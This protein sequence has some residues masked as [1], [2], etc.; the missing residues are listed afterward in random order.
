M[1]E[2]V[3]LLLLLVLLFLSTAAQVCREQTHRKPQDKAV[4]KMQGSRVIVCREHLNIVA[5]ATY[6]NLLDHVF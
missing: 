4:G 1:D 2:P 6:I 3:I 5:E